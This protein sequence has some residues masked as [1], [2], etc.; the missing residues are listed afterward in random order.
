[1]DKE[2]GRI[3]LIGST[4]IFPDWWPNK[5]TYTSEEQ[6]IAFTD[7]EEVALGRRVIDMEFEAAQRRYG[8]SKVFM[9]MFM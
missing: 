3:V 6:K 7:F 2:C 1:M 8:G 5:G 9:I 4:S